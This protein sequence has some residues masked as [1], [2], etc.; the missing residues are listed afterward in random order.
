MLHETRGGLSAL[1]SRAHS[2][3]EDTARPAPEATMKTPRG[4]SS[5]QDQ[6]YRI[7]QRILNTCILTTAHNYTKS[8]R[9]MPRTMVG[10][11]VSV[12]DEQHG[13][14][15]LEIRGLPGC[16]VIRLIWDFLYCIL[17]KS[18][19]RIIKWPFIIC[20]LNRAAQF[21]PISSGGA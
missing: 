10:L 19:E 21:S 2:P 8:T 12:G 16:G 18:F 20:Y 11:V 4:L 13:R 14:D 3:A 5:F 6:R 15:G 9:T 17:N 7:R 1:L